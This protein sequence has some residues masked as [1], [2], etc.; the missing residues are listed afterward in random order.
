[1]L[2][3]GH[4]SWARLNSD[5]V[6][7]DIRRR[8]SLSR[9]SYLGAIVASAI[10]VNYAVSISQSF[11]PT[12]PKEAEAKD[13]SVKMQ[14]STNRFENSSGYILSQETLDN[15]TDVS[16]V[17]GYVESQI[18]ALNDGKSV[19]CDPV[20]SFKSNGWKDSSGG[21]AMPACVKFKGGNNIKEHTLVFSHLKSG[22]DYVKATKFAG[23]FY[24][25][26]GAWTFASIK[27]LMSE[28]YQVE[29]FES[30]QITKI[31]DTL[32][33]DFPELYPPEEIE[34]LKKQFE[35]NGD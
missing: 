17:K 31:Q 16:E 24:K 4:M 10:L 27:L 18:K 1:M 5:D 30:V 11:I 6:L 26:D 25:N 32:I 7:S 14:L 29:G 34:R 13:I 33:N 23:I 22:E 2:R 21:Y 12:E 28:S 9:M 8:G 15:L 3:E 19:D 35:K 20:K